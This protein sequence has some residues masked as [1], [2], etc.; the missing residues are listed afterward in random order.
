MN[1]KYNLALVAVL[2]LGATLRLLHL[3]HQGLFLDE[4]WSWAVAQLSPMQI[5]ALSFH[6]PHPPLYYL[7]LKGST[8]ILPSTE[9]GLRILS[10]LCSIT[11]LA[12]TLLFVS[13]KWNNQAAIYAGLFVA[14]SSFDIYY[15]QETRMYT[16]LGLLWLLSYIILDQALQGH[17]YLFLGWSLVSVGMTW[18]HL[19]GILIVTTQLVFLGGREIW[20]IFHK[21]NSSLLD[22]WSGAS[23]ALT[24]MGMS[25]IIFL[26]WGYQASG[27]GGAW[28]PNWQDILSLL[29]LSTTGL[30]AG[31]EHFLDSAHLVLPPLKI[32]PLS[33]WL[34][35]GLILCGA[36]SVWGV[37]QEWQTRDEDRQLLALLGI[38]LIIGPIA[39]AFGYARLLDIRA[40]AFKPF[41]GTT[42][43]IYI[44]S[45][46]GLS[47]I[48]SSLLRRGVIFATLGVS[49][50]SLIPYYTT[51][52]KTNA[53]TTFQNLPAA[54]KQGALLMH[55]A[56]EAPVAFYY[57]GSGAKVWGLKTGNLLKISPNGILP[58]DFQPID[59]NDPE[60]QIVTDLWIYDPAKKSQQPEDYLPTCLKQKRLW[61]FEDN[62]WN[63]LKR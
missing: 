44:W 24:I 18:T 9:T 39:I 19:Y 27:A 32:V 21:Q 59:C 22:F 58:D 61:L 7:L 11:T 56:Y 12:V 16:L 6:D 49:L 13:R 8:T 46:V 37:L 42:Y 50:V 33:I 30:A 40:W 34:F 35:V 48:S 3:G 38:L 57:L 28:I 25:P 17:T 55:R 62:K 29:A 54:K 20:A 4:A 31:R 10:A 53:N 52:Q 47:K 43:L 60:T 51:W 1:R 14:F 41:L 26:L 15:A 2:G 36:F 5:V 63:L 45:G 23:T